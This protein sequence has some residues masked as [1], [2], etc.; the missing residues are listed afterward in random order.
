MR[1]ADW[2]ARVEDGV[3]GVADHAGRPLIHSVQG[4]ASLAAA[5]SEPGRLAANT[6]FV[7]LG[8]DAVRGP[9]ERAQIVERQILVVLA[10]RDVSDRLGA[11]RLTDLERLVDAIQ[12]SLIGWRPP[13]AQGLVFFVSGS[14]LDFARQSVWWQMRFAVPFVIQS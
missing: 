8:G 6:A 5:S 1:V 2:I 9:G 13:R 3:K 14:L 12:S 11:D 10:L 7:A 4:A